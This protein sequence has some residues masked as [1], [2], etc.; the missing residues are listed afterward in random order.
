MQV[1]QALA[2]YA[3]LPLGSQYIH[4]RTPYIKSVLLYGAEK[5]R[6]CVRGCMLRCRPNALQ[7]GVPYASRQM[8]RRAKLQQAYT[9]PHT[10]YHQTGKTLVKCVQWVPTLHSPPSPQTC[11]MLLT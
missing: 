4:E 11:T 2:E 7:G 1:R 5:V 8:K 3:I 9:N 6:I 10:S